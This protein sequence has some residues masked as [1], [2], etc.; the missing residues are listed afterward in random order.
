MKKK[1]PRYDV[2]FEF[3]D[4]WQ[5]YWFFI[6]L[7]TD[8]WQD[9][10]QRKILTFTTAFLSSLTNCWFKSIMIFFFR[11]S[12]KKTVSRI[13][14]CFPTHATLRIDITLWLLSRQININKLFYSVFAFSW[15]FQ[16]NILKWNSVSTKFNTVT[17]IHW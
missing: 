6:I 16:L 14:T 15:K 9:I 5:R 10:L 2:S 13:R 4:F 17:F 11:E 8:F 3:N 7:S 12:L 1:P